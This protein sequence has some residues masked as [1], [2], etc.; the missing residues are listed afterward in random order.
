[1]VQSK[2]FNPAANTS[3]QTPSISASRISRL[4]DM[5]PAYGH[6]TATPTIDLNQPQYLCVS[7]WLPSIR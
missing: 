7:R 2:L 4:H 6:A 5:Q 1:M 3:S